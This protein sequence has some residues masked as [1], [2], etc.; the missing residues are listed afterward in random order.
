M[1][2]YVLLAMP[3]FYAQGDNI[4]IARRFFSPPPAYDVD[5]ASAAHGFLHAT[6]ETSMMPP[7]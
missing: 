4:F 6:V 3:P 1:P 7:R 5:D 2:I